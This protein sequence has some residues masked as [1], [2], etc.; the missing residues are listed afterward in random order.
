[1]LVIAIT[2]AEFASLYVQNGWYE[3]T[4]I[5][6]GIVTIATCFWGYHLAC[7]IILP[8][9]SMNT[10]LGDQMQ[11]KLK[12]LLSL[13]GGAVVI[14]CI[15]QTVFAHDDAK[16]NHAAVAL[17]LAIGVCAG[18]FS[19][20]VI[21]ESSLLAGVVGDM[22]NMS[23]EEISPVLCRIAKLRGSMISFATL[24]DLVKITLLLARPR[25]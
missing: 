15:P 18:V 12:V 24:S 10:T 8:L 2:P 23:A 14:C 20:V 4:S 25:P 3:G 19:L 7:F 5:S 9:F 13:I 21:R 22:Q 16:F 11:L 6:L 17:N 1:M